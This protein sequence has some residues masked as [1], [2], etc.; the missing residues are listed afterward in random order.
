MK[1]YLI[2]DASHMF[3]RSRYSVRGDKSEKTGMCLHILFNCISK[4]WRVNKADHVVFAFDGRS[5]RKD[6]YKPYKANRLTKL[7]VEEQ[8]ENKL[9]FEA[10]DIFKDFIKNKTNCTVLENPILEA[11]DLIAGFIQNHAEDNHIIVSND[12]DFEQLLDENVEMYNGIDDVTI[13]TNGIYDYKGNQLT[14]KKTGLPKIAPDPE[15]SVFEKCIRGCVSDNIFSAYP[16]I[17][18]KGTKNKIGL[19]EAYTDRSKKGF[20]WSS[21]MFHRWLDHNGQEHRVLDDYERN[22][23][24]I[25]LTQQP[26]NIRNIIN[27]TIS[28]SCITK[29]ISQ[30]GLYF[31]KLCGR[32]ELV[33]ISERANE[34]AIIFGSKY[35]S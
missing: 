34:F 1:K 30:I 18:E 28:K 17:R 25:D 7:S 2:I 21:V 15:W 13:T 16:G 20:N 22:K 8:E 31:L 32:F 11:D 26:E 4:A 23:Q 10:F 5:W 35:E 6:I 27:E 24:L 14:D 9:F 3:W 33:K 29:N 12:A 19:R